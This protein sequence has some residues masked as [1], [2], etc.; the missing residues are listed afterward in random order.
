ME[1]RKWNG[2]TA[3]RNGNF[4]Q[5]RATMRCG[6]KIA[7]HRTK[8]GV[9]GDFGGTVSRWSDDLLDG[10]DEEIEL[11]LHCQTRSR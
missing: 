7:R 10:E 4:L 9:G 8:C 11:E 5:K 1:L 2:K 6:N 3:K